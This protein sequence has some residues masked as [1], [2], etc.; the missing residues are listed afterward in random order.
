LVAVV[1]T[2]VLFG[3]PVSVGNTDSSTDT[4]NEQVLVALTVPLLE[5]AVQT[6]FEMPVGKRVPLGGTQK[7]VPSVE[8]Q[9]ATALCTQV[10]TDEHTP[11]TFVTMLPGQ[12]SV[13]GTLL[14][15]TITRKVQLLVLPE[16]SVA[17]QSTLF[18]PFGKL[19]PLAG[20]QALLTPAQLS[21]TVGAKITIWLL[22][23]AA[24]AFVE[25]FA[26]QVIVGRT[27]SFTVM[28]NEAFA[29]L[30]DGSLAV[31][32]TVLVPIGKLAPL[33]GTQ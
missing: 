15:V 2:L 27:D 31:Q 11:E 8:P 5:T 23:V 32:F 22:Q 21:L 12:F 30:P 7:L 17:V 13:G 29:V 33:A 18:V 26:G 1:K 19:E 14:V 25:M 28:K 10:T 3:L 24:L 20:L 6:T 16:A 9:L 4:V